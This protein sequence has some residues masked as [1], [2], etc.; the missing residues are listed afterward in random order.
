MQGWIKGTVKRH[1]AYKG[2]HMV[3]CF[4][5][6]L[7][8]PH[9][10]VFDY[11]LFFLTFY[12]FLN[13]AFL[14]WFSNLWF[15]CN[16]WPIFQI[17]E[18]NTEKLSNLPKVTEL[19]RGSVLVIQSCPALYDPMGCSP[20]GSP[21]HVDSPCKNT[22]VGSHS[23]LQGIFLTQ[24]PNPGLPNCRQMLHQ[25]SHE[26]RG[27]AGTWIPCSVPMVSHGTMPWQVFYTEE[28]MFG[29]D[30]YS[31]RQRLSI[32]IFRCRKQGLEKWRAVLYE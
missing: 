7:L 1:R 19:V 25:L 14:H 16:Y 9:K 2:D 4:R 3:D 31:L 11:A 13:Q 32:H 28:L 5:I 8:E 29:L 6:W 22:G 20:P 17:R 24:G 10:L 27:S 18:S 23:L 15:G 21:T 12:L 26:V 30:K